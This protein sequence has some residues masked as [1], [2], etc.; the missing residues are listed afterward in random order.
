MKI[1][2]DTNVL[3]ADYRMSGNAFRIFFEGTQRTEVKVYIPQIVIDELLVN[4]QEQVDLLLNDIDKLRRK[5]KRL[6]DLLDESLVTRYSS[7]AITQEYQKSLLQV[8]K[9]KGITI[10]PYPN[11]PHE[12]IVRRDLQ[13]RRPFNRNGA[14]YRD[15]L[16]WEAI[17]SLLK[18]QKGQILFVTNNSKDFGEGP[19]VLPDLLRDLEELNFGRKNVKIYR[20]LDALNRELFIPQLER[21]N[22]MMALLATDK[23]PQFSLR[24]WLQEHLV[25][26]LYEDGWHYALVDLEEGHGEVTI[27]R[28]EIKEVT[29]D[30]VRALLSGDLLVS[31]TVEVKG[32]TMVEAEWDD[33]L[34][35]KDL[36]ELLE[37]DDE[38]GKFEWLTADIPFDSV[39]IAFSLILDQHTYRVLSFG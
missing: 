33:Y 1:V 38:T 14:G 17:L 10:L 31:A 32:M 21:L 19:S 12:K 25:D 4:F 22:E 7:R 20:T 13:R 18:E 37:D 27:K 8:L 16:I 6:T 28:L 11:V 36:Q 3:V 23:I 26:Y 35:H 39:S 30:D 2:L 29:I 9:E 15:A 34:S 24:L 5:A